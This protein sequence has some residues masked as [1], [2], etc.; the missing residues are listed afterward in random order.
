[1]KV[2][3]V[4]S[5]NQKLGSRL[6]AWAASFEDL[7]LEAV[8]SHVAVLIDETWIFESTMLSGVRVLPYEAWLQ[9]NEELYRLPSVVDGAT[10]L[11]LA[12]ETWGRKYDWKGLLYFALCYIGLIVGRKLPEHNK[13]QRDRHYFCTELVA[14]LE[15]ADFSMSSPA[16]ICERMLSK[17]EGVEI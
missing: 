3:Y 17:F 8:P 1:M 5:R 7:E 16:K 2:E 6:I 11:K 9:I 13:W 15:R 14:R 10:A 12:A 4:F